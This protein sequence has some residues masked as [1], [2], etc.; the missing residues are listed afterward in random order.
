MSYQ[1]LLWVDIFHLVSILKGH[2]DAF[3]F[4]DLSAK[5]IKTTFLKETIDGEKTI[6]KSEDLILCGS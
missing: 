1:Y 2:N 5:K 6:K 3:R 4:K